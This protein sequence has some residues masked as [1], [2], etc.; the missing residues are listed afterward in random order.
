MN[1]WL[2]MWTR[3]RATIRQIVNDDPKR[4]TLLVAALIGIAGVEAC[5]AMM[6]VREARPLA[7]IPVMPAVLAGAVQ[8][9]MGLYVGALLIQWT[10]K[11]IRSTADRTHIR[12]ALAWSGVPTAWSLVIWIAI[13]LMGRRASFTDGTSNLDAN[14]QL[15]MLLLPLAVSGTVMIAWHPFVMFKALAEVQGVSA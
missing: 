8:G 12:A 3:P 11:L 13:N 2:S 6:V 14:P 1:P 15:P 5:D 7:R 9:V 4:L 10:G